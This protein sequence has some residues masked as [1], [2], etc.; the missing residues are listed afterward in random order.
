M[1]QVQ[2]LVNLQVGSGPIACFANLLRRGERVNRHSA[3]PSWGLREALRER[4]L[5][6]SARYY[7]RVRCGR[8]NS[9]L[10]DQKSPRP[11]ILALFNQSNYILHRPEPRFDP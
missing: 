5:N 2:D 7:M 3:L 10:S 11:Q 1:G 4:N 9:A 8:V 6:S